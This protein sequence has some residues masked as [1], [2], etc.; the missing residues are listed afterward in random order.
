MNFIEIFIKFKCTCHDDT[1]LLLSPKP[2]R[3]SQLVI[4]DANN[5]QA[6]VT[7]NLSRNSKSHCLEAS[8]FTCTIKTIKNNLNIFTDLNFFSKKSLCYDEE[9]I[10]MLDGV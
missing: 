3:S 8:L 4:H 6:I 9:D 5:W 7:V 2:S 10:F 1:H